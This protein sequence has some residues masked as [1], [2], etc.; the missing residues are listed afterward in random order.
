MFCK[1]ILSIR[2]CITQGS[3]TLFTPRMITEFLCKEKIQLAAITDVNT[4]L[5][6]PA[7]SICCKRHGILA[8]YG[9]E[10]WCRD[11]KALVLFTSLNT[12]MDFNYA[13]YR[14][15]PA[16]LPQNLHG[17]D[18]RQYCVDE[19]DGI[20]SVEKKYLQVASPVSFNELKK[21]VESKGGLVFKN[22]ALPDRYKQPIEE[23]FQLR[24]NFLDFDIGDCGLFSANE[25]I[26]FQAI[27][28]GFEKLQWS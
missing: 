18:P 20:L 23:I 14:T 2:T 8:L 17:Q 3:P 19:D 24:K 15:L 11:R 26:N 10:A 4:C 22:E 21:E 5:N 16:D 28:T 7:F 25:S 12:A 9:M 27:R 6:A 1:A 13:W